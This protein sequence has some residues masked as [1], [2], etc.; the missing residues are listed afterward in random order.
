MFVTFD[1]FTLRLK[2]IDFPDH[3]FYDPKS[4]TYQ[5]PVSTVFAF[6]TTRKIFL[7][8]K[9][10][11]IFFYRINFPDCFGNLEEAYCKE[12]F[13]PTLANKCSSCHT[14]YTLMN[15]V[16]DKNCPEVDEFPFF[17][18]LG[19]LKCYKCSKFLSHCKSCYRKYIKDEIIC[20][21]CL[22]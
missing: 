1:I 2:L 3:F 18:Q 20:T 13:I 16:C 4:S 21:T 17:D 9:K 8:S 19:N 15:N 5:D 11:T 7:I 10:N 14:G 12:C 22:G 6:D